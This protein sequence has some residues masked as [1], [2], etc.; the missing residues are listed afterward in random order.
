MAT[1]A[2]DAVGNIA[3]M[4]TKTQPLANFTPGLQKQWADTDKRRQSSLMQW[5]KLQKE[6]GQLSKP[7]YKKIGGYLIPLDT[8][9]NPQFIDTLY[10]TAMCE[11]TAEDNEVILKNYSY[12][13]PKYKTD[14]NGAPQVVGYERKSLFEGPSG[15]HWKMGLIEKM[16][17][18]PEDW[19]NYGD[20]Y[21]KMIE[22]VNAQLEIS[23]REGW[24][25]YSNRTKTEK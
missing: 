11:G 25:S 10:K 13:V 19:E 24:H 16:Y 18:E 22:A 17:E 2:A 9:Y 14:K 8:W 1:A 12:E 20:A 23:S 5:W 21:N 15:H 4:A 6:K 3:A 7:Q